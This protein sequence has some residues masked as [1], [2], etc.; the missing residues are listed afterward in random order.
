[1]IVVTGA[2]RGLGKAIVDRLINKGNRVIQLSRS[3]EGDSADFMECDVGDY[4]SVKSVAKKLKK[5]D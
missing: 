2:S 3:Y 1:M 5:M 4:F